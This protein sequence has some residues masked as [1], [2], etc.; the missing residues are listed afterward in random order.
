MSELSF[1]LGQQIAEQKEEIE[2]LKVEI[3]HKDKR[4]KALIIELIGTRES[5]LQDKLFGIPVGQYADFLK[6]VEEQ[7]ADSANEVFA[8]LQKAREEAA[9]LRNVNEELSDSLAEAEEGIHDLIRKHEAHWRAVADHIGGCFGGVD[10]DV[11]DPLG[12]AGVVIAHIRNLRDMLNTYL[13]PP[14]QL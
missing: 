3:D 7:S 13:Y 1:H 8:A 4:I 14:G 2:A 10:G 5:A 11:K 6:A 9:E 12:N